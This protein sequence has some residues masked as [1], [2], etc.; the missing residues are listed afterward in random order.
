MSISFK[1]EDV[2]IS[3]IRDRAMFNTFAGNQS[4]VISDIG[5]ELAVTSSASSFV[6]SLGTGEAVICG[7]S[8]LSEGTAETLTLGAN[9]TGYIAIEIDMSQTGSNICRLVNVSSLVQGNINN[10]IDMVYDLPL[11]QYT[12][13]SSG[14]SSL[15]DVRNIIDNPAQAI[16][17]ELSTVAR[18]GR[19]SDL[20]NKPSIDSA[21]S[22]TSTNAVQNKVI[23][24]ALNG[25]ANTPDSAL[26]SSSTNPVQNKVINTALSGKAN[27]SHAHGNVT[28]G[29]D[30]TSNVLIANGDRLVINDES[31]SKL[32][33]STITFDGSTTT[34]LLSRK[35][36][37]TTAKALFQV[38]FPVGSIYVNYDNTNPSTIIGGTWELLASKVDVGGTIKG[39]G[40]TLGLYDGTENFGVV[41]GSDNN[42]YNGGRFLYNGT[43]VYNKSTGTTSYSSGLTKTTNA[44]RGVGLTST[45]SG[46]GIIADTVT[47]YLWRRTA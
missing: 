37:W 44:Y 18:T 33:N 16:I 13:N 34:S 15:T 21:L 14:V 1:V 30:I 46:S 35:G 25:K 12:T 47:C 4:Y 36:T 45:A 23:N 31:D 22:S 5:D 27:T 8:M 19:Y 24:T 42:L 38:L 11:Y 28:S 43:N 29:G 7:G 6:V 2:E 9:E 41:T 3:A 39:N 17:G 40:K 26:S 10:G 32:A 20:T